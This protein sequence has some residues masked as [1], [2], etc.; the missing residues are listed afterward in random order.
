MTQI[1]HKT[2]IIEVI[3]AELSAPIISGQIIHFH[4]INSR[5]TILRG[6]ENY[7]L[8]LSLTP[9]PQ[10]PRVCY[11]ERWGSHHFEPLGKI[12]LLPPNETL[13]GKADGANHSQ[14]TI[15]CHLNPEAMREWFEGDLEWTDHRLKASLDISSTNIH[16]LL[17]RFGDEMKNPGFASDVVIELIAAQL[18]IDLARYCTTVSESPASGGLAPWRMR[19]I[20]ERL[21]DIH[22]A[23]TL[24]E[25]ANICNM[26]IRQLARAF[27]SSRNCSIG[28]YVAQCRIENAKKLLSTEQSIK[29]IAYS[30]G[31]ASSCNFSHAF[32]RSTGKTPSEYRQ[33]TQ[34]LHTIS[35]DGRNTHL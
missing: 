31:F 35:H 5:E 27:R 10:N 17:L 16:N 11:R 20:E 33:G 12:F 19:L 29:A 24:A 4:N 18:A 34:K 8:D 25:L 32:R 1:K 2:K 3:E 6:N 28:D 22:K 23:P 30:L 7:R 13:I 21:R 26:S 9:R 15:L 14:A